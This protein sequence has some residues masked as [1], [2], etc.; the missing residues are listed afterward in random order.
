V[1]FY[2]RVFTIATRF[3]VGGAELNSQL[4]ASRLNSDFSVTTKSIFIMY[5]NGDF[6]GNQSCICLLPAET[7]NPVKL[8]LAFF[9]LLKIIYGERPDVLIGFQ[10]LANVFGSISVLFSKI[11]FIATQRNPSSSQGKAIGYLE[12]L[13]GSTRLYSAN[14]AVSKAVI[15]SYRGYPGSYFRKLVC[16]YNGF[17]ER[18][19]KIRKSE[20]RERLD[21]PQNK[22]IVGFL[23]RLAYQ[24]YPEFLLDVVSE[25]S[26]PDVVLVYA[27]EGEELVSLNERV[28]ELG[29]A[30]HVLFVGQVD[31]SRV[32]EFYD[33]IDV[34]LLPSRFEGFGR[35]LVE[36]MQSSVP[37]L[38]NKLEVTQEVLS[39]ELC[40][41][42][43]NAEAWAD[44]IRELLSNP[45][46]YAEAC[47]Y[48]EER[49][50]FFSIDNMIG[51][52]YKVIVKVL[53][54]R[55]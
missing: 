34:F 29:L 31:F 33:A 40:V 13:L 10:P 3:G 43:L 6:P 16:V 21:L 49:A 39:N 30:D 18:P 46:G 53:G 48:G 8:L 41:I 42:E 24:K 52:Y 15:N 54:V 4:L 44:R 27:G 12:K 1:E 25:L 45:A 36:A 28:T 22:K 26:I 51:G 37:V 17:P 38:A 32:F 20:A 14:I 19:E 2:V 50:L 55:S 47:D 7:N 11:K 35:T 5:A 9:R 23:G